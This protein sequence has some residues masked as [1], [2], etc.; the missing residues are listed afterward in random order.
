MIADIG[1]SLPGMMAPIKTPVAWPPQK[2]CMPNHIQ[3]TKHRNM[4][5]TNSVLVSNWVMR[6]QI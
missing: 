6:E 4:T 2:A 5:G 1:E 3:A